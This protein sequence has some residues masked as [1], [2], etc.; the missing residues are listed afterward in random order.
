MKTQRKLTQWFTHPN[1]ALPGVYKR[2]R[3]VTFH[4]S[5]P[6]VMVVT[7]NYWD[8]KLWGVGRY[9]PEE[10]AKFKKEYSLF[11]FLPWCGLAQDPNS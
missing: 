7:Y 8:G 10:A 11:Q 1:P 6:G 2:K 3:F 5:R 9:T 4:S